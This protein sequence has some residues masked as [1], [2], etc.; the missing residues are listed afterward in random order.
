MDRSKM[1]QWRRMSV[2][3]LA[4]LGV[5]VALSGCVIEPIGYPHYYHPYRYYGG[6]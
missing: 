3:L 5:S 4:A 2:R 6:Y 1:A